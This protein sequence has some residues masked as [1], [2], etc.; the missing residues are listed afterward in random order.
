MNDNTISARMAVLLARDE[1]AKQPPYEGQAA[2]LACCDLFLAITADKLRM[3]AMG[4]DEP[5][6]GA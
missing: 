1:E 3:A 6:G 2:V 5:G 4:I